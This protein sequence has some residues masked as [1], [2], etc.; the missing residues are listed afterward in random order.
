MD[1]YDFSERLLKLRREK[2]LSQKELGDLLGVSNKAI[3]K[4]ENG[5]SMPKTETMLKLAGL[6]G[7]D[8]NELLGIY[9]T[10]TEDGNSFSEELGKLQSENLVLQQ[11]IASQEKKKKQFVTGAVILVAAVALITAIAMLLTD[12]GGYKN[13]ELADAGRDGSK[14]IF[15]NTEYLP[16]SE[17]QNGLFEFNLGSFN[18]GFEQKYA[19]F[20][21]A[22]GSSKNV[23]V[24][25]NTR[26]R[27]LKLRTKQGSFYYIDGDISAELSPE[28]LLS[29]SLNSGTIANNG[30]Y[31]SADFYGR[32][33]SVNPEEYIK[34]GS[35]CDFYNKL[36]N[37]VDSKITELYLGNNSKTVT[38]QFKNAYLPE[39]KAGE[40]FEDGKNELYFY[41]YADAQSYAAGEELK[42]FVNK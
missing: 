26:Y 7:I 29:V 31:Y 22:D 2:G 4:W 27:L 33:Y 15:N 30:N 36:D 28:N 6:L 37:P 20:V 17:T 32:Y 1:K 38:V 23:T 21:S 11:K 10:P 19:K 35:F 5:E 3:S 34:I 40:F 14:I 41:N 12:K 25:G 18:D 9:S 42:A 13:P 24:E 16:C 8:G 39:I